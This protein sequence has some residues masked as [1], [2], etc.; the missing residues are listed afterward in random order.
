M[1]ILIYI[2]FILLDKRNKCTLPLGTMHLHTA[3]RNHLYSING[4]KT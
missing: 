4:Y 1:L 3:N 2:T